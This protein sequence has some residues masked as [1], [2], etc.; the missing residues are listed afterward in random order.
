MFP[1]HGAFSFNNS[2]FKFEGC[3]RDSRWLR[4]SDTRQGYWDSMAW[5]LPRN[6]CV[7][8]S[9]KLHDRPWKL[10]RALPRSRP[11]PK[12]I[13]H[14]CPKAAK[15]FCPRICS[16]DLSHQTTCSSRTD[17]NT[18]RPRCAWL[19]F[20]SWHPSWSSPPNPLW[21]NYFTS[22]S[23]SSGQL[24]TASRQGLM[25]VITFL[26]LLSVFASM[27]GKNALFLS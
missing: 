21:I 9:W 7:L 27:E 12:G 16:P 23:K 10:N 4:C 14:L 25:S 6:G 11:V 5:L 15:C 8:G 13:P 3:S 1:Q 18:V 17:G 2:P 26:N 20:E 22:L 19:A 24:E